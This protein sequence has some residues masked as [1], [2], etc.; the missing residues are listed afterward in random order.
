MPLSFWLTLVGC[1]FAFVPVFLD[2]GA[3]QNLAWREGTV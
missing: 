1:I 2:H 3:V